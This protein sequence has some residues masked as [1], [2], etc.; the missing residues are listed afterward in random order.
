MKREKG[1]IDCDCIFRLDRGLSRPHKKKI[2]ERREG[3]YL[4]ILV[5]CVVILFLFILFLYLFIFLL[6]FGRLF[7]FVSLFA[8]LKAP[9]KKLIVLG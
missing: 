5:C 8:I 6:L 4:L 7:C 9:Q 3:I 1:K 2:E